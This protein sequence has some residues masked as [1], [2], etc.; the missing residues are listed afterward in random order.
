MHELVRATVEKSKLQL[1]GVSGPTIDPMK[2]LEVRNLYARFFQ[3]HFNNLIVFAISPD[4]RNEIISRWYLIRDYIIFLRLVQRHPIYPDRPHSVPLIN[5]RQIPPSAF[6]DVIP[7]SP[8]Q[9]VLTQ[10][11][12]RLYGTL[13]KPWRQVIM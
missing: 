6:S 5:V 13:L 12:Q 8:P 4:W 7:A 11:W 3:M 10:T 9:S 1:K 2:S